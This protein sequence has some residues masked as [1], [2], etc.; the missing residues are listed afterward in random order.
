[1]TMRPTRQTRCASL[2]LVITALI[3]PAGASPWLYGIHFYGD[4]GDGGV[5]TMTGGKGIWSL[6][7]VVPNSDIW[8]GAAWQRD[9]RFLGMK[10][11]GH[12]II[13]RIEPQWGYA[14]PKE[15]DYPMAAYLPQVTSAA[16]TLEDVVNIWQ[17]G[18][19]MNLYDEWGGEVLTPAAYVAAY[20]EIR[21]AI[22]AV[23]SSLGEQQVLV[24]P[25]SPGAPAG[26]RHTDGLEYL[27]EM[28]ALLDPNEI[29][30]FALHA[31]GPP[32]LDADG[33][34][35]EFEAGLLS[36][37]IVIDQ[38]GL[39]D[40]PVYV[41]EFNRQTNPADPA[42]EAFSAQFLSGVYQDLAEWNQKPGAHPVSA[43][44]WFIYQYDD[45][46][47]NQYSIGYLHTINPS[48]PANDLYDAFQWACGQDYASV[49][50]DMLKPPR[51]V[52]AAPPGVNVAAQATL[53]VD[54][55]SSTANFAVDG[56]LSSSDVWRTTTSLP[57]HWLQLDLGSE[58]VL[59]GFR[60]YHHE[61]AGGFAQF[62]LD[63]FLLETAPTSAGPW[64]IEAPVYNTT[65]TNERTF[66]IPR[67]RQYVRLYVT[68]CG[69]DNTVR[70]P[71]IEVLAIT[72]GDFDQNAA[73]DLHD[74]AKAQQCATMSGSLQDSLDCL[75]GHFDEDGDI[76]A[77]DA[78]A[79]FTVL[80][81]P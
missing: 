8:W 7:I 13:C 55:G 37:L 28:C 15:L 57:I 67:S 49:L 77:D 5:E 79:L 78:D 65:A 38:A 2:S 72:R 48:G 43:A 12:S 25:L 31:Y 64:T 70:L 39:S 34:R 56:A 62:N 45:V 11:N 17:I 20:R 44:C 26:A 68:D 42:S 51:M 24:G 47:W 27:A 52:D 74:F 1:M 29:D 76:D 3:S 22:K 60:V 75:W 9:N 33:A 63:A 23:P 30:G 81:G 69:R 61:A 35:A 36:Q 41:T 59:S 58:Q 10:A 14:V 16:M 18:N 6:E 32:W 66:T 46:V 4:A 19:E 40:K 71:E 80:T 50:P 53:S 54:S 73:V 21:T